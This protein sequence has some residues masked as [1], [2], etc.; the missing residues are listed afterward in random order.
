M[1]F[2]T[3]LIG[4]TSLTMT[5]QTYA[6]HAGDDVEVQMKDSLAACCAIKLE[7]GQTLGLKCLLNR[8]GD[9]LNTGHIGPDGLGWQGQDIGCGMLRDYQRVAGRLREDIEKCQAYRVFIDFQARHLSAQNFGED[10]IGVIGRGQMHGDGLSEL[11]LARF[12]PML[13]V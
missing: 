6:I 10:V 9:L 8:V 12:P 13:K 3:V 1:G 5:F 2:E 7:D 4:L 11:T